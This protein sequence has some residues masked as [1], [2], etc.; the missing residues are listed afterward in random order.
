M[1]KRIFKAGIA[2]LLA[3]SCVTMT[4]QSI[5][6]ETNNDEYHAYYRKQLNEENERIFYNALLE[7]Y[8]NGNLK[9][10]VCSYD[11]T[12]QLG[13]AELSRYAAGDLAL[14][15]Q[16]QNARDAFMGDYAEIF[17][18]D[19]SKISLRVGSDGHG[20]VAN[21]GNGGYADLYKDSRLSSADSIENMEAQLNS[22]VSSLTEQARSYA[23]RQEQIRFVHDAIVE[24]VDY[25]YREEASAEAAPHVDDAVGAFVFGQAWCEGYARAFKMVMDRLEIPSV[26]VI[27]GGIRSS[28]TASSTP[29]VENHMWNDVQMEDG[30]WYAV[31]VTFDDPISGNTVSRDKFLLKGSDFF[32]A[33]HK[34]TGELSQGGKTFAYPTLSLSNYGEVQAE[35]ESKIKIL[36][37]NGETA[38][39]EGTDGLISYTEFLFEYDGMTEAQMKEKGMRWAVRSQYK[40]EQGELQY[41]AWIGLNS[42]GDFE[43]SSYIR[44]DYNDQS[45]HVLGYEFAVTTNLQDEINLDVNESNLVELS[46]LYAVND[47]HAYRTRP[48]IISA[49]PDPRSVY[50]GGK[51]KVTLVYDSPLVAVEGIEPHLEVTTEYSNPNFS[52]DNLQWENT[53]QIISNLN[54]ERE[55][56]VCIVTFD[57]TPDMSYNYSGTGYTF[58]LVGLVGK[59]NGSVPKAYSLRRQEYSLSVAPCPLRTPPD[60]RLLSAYPK[61][62]MSSYPYDMF[63][64][65]TGSLIQTT[66]GSIGLSLIASKVSEENEAALDS[67]LASSGVHVADSSLVK[68]YQTYDLAISCKGTRLS[69]KKGNKLTI[70]LP[71]PNGFDPRTMQG[72]TFEAYHFTEQPEG[73]GQYVAEKLICNATETGLWVIVDSFSPFAVV[74]VDSAKAPKSEPVLSVN[75]NEVMASVQIEGSSALPAATVLEPLDT[76]KTVILSAKEGYILDA[77]MV[78]GTRLESSQFESSETD[79]SAQYRV[80]IAAGNQDVAMT[81]AFKARTVAEKEAE[82]GFE[83]IL[84]IVDKPQL[85]ETPSTPGT[86][87]DSASNSENLPQNESGISSLVISPNQKTS[88]VPSKTQTKETADPTDEPTVHPEASAESQPQATP[89][90]TAVP[91]VNADAKTEK[92]SK[93][94]SIWP[95]VIGG[96]AVLLLAGAACFFIKNYVTDKE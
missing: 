78:N 74:M 62:A 39:E 68:E 52:V 60:S 73:S 9:E 44:I 29:I 38:S 57:F 55:Q 59:A 27:G 76:E 67:A 64:D 21:V 13:Q 92:N 22:A 6:A 65:P 42:Y 10:G 11:V 14:A 23:T 58:N 80:T 36:V 37:T 69:I 33:Q 96:A 7:L 81:A 16:F 83:V 4:K 19:W 48:W 50:Y 72:V 94:N 71:Y 86:S 34:E 5:H 31:D 95:W 26:L 12:L 28:E 85:P 2:L 1:T 45:A 3:L 51:T 54:G 8:L 15:R 56:E 89:K 66:Q 75:T 53:T 17:Y 77:L 93:S 87:Q 91:S 40:D 90:S 88:Y 47:Q 18:V 63:E 24:R 20:Y 70:A 49:S 41:S 25:T 32:C 79:S 35:E 46:D 61:P 84:P 82:E 43:N 30:Q